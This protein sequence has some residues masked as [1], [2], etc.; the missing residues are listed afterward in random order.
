MELL[1]I[2]AKVKYFS[3]ARDGKYKMLNKSQRER[4][5]EKLRQKEK[6]LSLQAIVERLEEDFP[7]CREK[8][9]N[10]S[11]SLKTRLV[12]DTMAKPQK[13]VVVA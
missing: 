8:L 1:S 3:A 13:E 6:L 4:E 5:A 7:G 9:R 10:V 11:M 12:E 2:Q